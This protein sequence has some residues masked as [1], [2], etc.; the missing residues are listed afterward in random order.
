M[1]P[2]LKDSLQTI[3]LTLNSLMNF[4]LFHVSYIAIWVLALLQGVLTLALLRH[5]AELRGLMKQT[6]GEGAEEA[7]KEDDFLPTGSR[8]PEFAG[9]DARS[10]KPVGIHNLDG[11]GAMLFLSSEC[12]LCKGLAESLRQYPLNGQHPIIAVCRGGKEA[13]MFFGKRLSEDIYL[14]SEEAEE[15][16]KLYHVSSYPTLVVIGPARIVRGYGHPSDVENLRDL[17]ERNL[18]KAPVGVEVMSQSAT[19][20]S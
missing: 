19:L 13:A 7:F 3:E 1:Q 20:R 8:A 2:S 17:L 11:G 15:T 14:M 10:G 18:N 4:D 12:R 9:F 6:W 5:L 16:A